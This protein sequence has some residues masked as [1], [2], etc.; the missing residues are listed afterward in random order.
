MF[1]EIYIHFYIKCHFNRIK[2]MVT[3]PRHAAGAGDKGEAFGLDRA[4]HFP[5]SYNLTKCDI[6]S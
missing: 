3:N 5:G 2:K 6:G 4:L 1:A